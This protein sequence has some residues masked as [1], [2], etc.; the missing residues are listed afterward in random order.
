MKTVSHATKPLLFD[1]SRAGI[2]RDGNPLF[3]ITVAS[4]DWK[5]FGN[6]LGYTD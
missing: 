5:K 1:D 2:E 4:S 3:G 6:W